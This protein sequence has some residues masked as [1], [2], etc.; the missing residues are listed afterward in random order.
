V[1]ELEDVDKWIDDP[2]TLV[3]DGHHPRPVI[4]RHSAWWPDPQVCRHATKLVDLLDP[5][6]GPPAARDTGVG[7]NLS[8]ALNDK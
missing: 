4:H 1:A 3:P 2:V 8:R 5:P 7:A 6:P